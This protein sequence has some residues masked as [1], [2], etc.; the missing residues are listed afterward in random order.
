MTRQPDDVMARMPELPRDTSPI[1][2]ALWSSTIVLNEAVRRGWPRGELR[3]AMFALCLRF[4]LDD[5][6]DKQVH[7][8]IQALLDQL[9]AGGAVPQ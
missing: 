2:A 8:E 9:R 7:S 4:G 5:L 1:G 3:R 6:S